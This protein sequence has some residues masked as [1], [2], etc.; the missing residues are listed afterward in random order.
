MGF[1]STSEV[2]ECSANDL[3]GQYVGQT[4]PKTR[5]KLEE[6]LGRVLFID[7]AYRLMYGSYA[8][9]AVDEIIYFLTQPANMGKMIVILVGFVADMHR[10]MSMFPTLCGL[11]P[12]EIV[13]EHIPPEDCITLLIRELARSN[14]HSVSNFL[15]DTES[16][17]YV[18]VKRLFRILAL[19]PSWSNA[20]DVKNL[21][22]QI[23]GQFLESSDLDSRPDQ[24][25]SVGLITG[26]MTRMIAQR[27]DRLTA[28]GTDGNMT[29]PQQPPLGEGNL[30]QI[31][32]NPQLGPP[33]LPSD[34]AICVAGMGS[35][36][37]MDSSIHTRHGETAVQGQTRID[38]QESVTSNQEIMADSQ[39]TEDPD[40]ND[41]EQDDLDDDAGFREDG[42]PDSVWR[43]LVQT[44]KEEIRRKK[45]MN[46]EIDQLE[47]GLKDAETAAAGNS[48][49]GGDN[50]VNSTDCDT[51]RGQLTAIQRR[52]HDEDKIYK[53]LEAMNRCVNGFCWYKVVGGW[54]CEG[55]MHFV[56][57]SEL[58]TR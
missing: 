21:A 8:A 44:Q 42:V 27:R 35:T 37:A 23:L 33:P 22:R 31:L 1:L 7:E 4:G 46:A 51:L 52:M 24:T 5:K 47:R 16:E 25:L 58:L 41:E 6:G 55:G 40:A 29:L 53:A 13:F 10:L 36:C 19:I 9:E 54:R 50:P 32:E 48:D 34:P 20:R 56:T 17:G 26:C 49:G 2:I 43:E 38:L 57:D 12:E 45:Q 39:S 15:D 18:Q 14:I 28:L 11:F 30:G 3:L